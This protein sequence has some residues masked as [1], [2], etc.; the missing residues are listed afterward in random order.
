MAKTLYPT[1]EYQCSGNVE[2]DFPGL[3][4]LLDMKD[5][6]AVSTKQPASSTTESEGGVTGKQGS[7]TKGQTD[8]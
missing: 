2:I 1:D 3:C 4:A 5:L 7:W 8:T 6:P